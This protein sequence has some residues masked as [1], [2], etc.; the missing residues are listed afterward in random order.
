MNWNN[1]SKELDGPLY[2]ILCEVKNGAGRYIEVP[3]FKG[4]RVY[5][6][7]AGAGDTS[8]QCEDERGNTLQFSDSESFIKYYEKNENRP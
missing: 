5:T 7:Q 3:Y 1:N 8:L 4:K 2:A 6:M